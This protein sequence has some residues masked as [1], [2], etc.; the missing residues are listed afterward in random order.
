L[1][2]EEVVAVLSPAVGG[3]VRF[4]RQQ[5]REVDFLGADG[6]HFLTDDGFHLAEHPQSQRQPGVNAGSG[7][8]D[9]A[10]T[11]QQAVAGDVGVGRVFAQGAQEKGGK[12]KDHAGYP[13]LQPVAAFKL[14]Q[15][16][17]WEKKENNAP[18]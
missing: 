2:A 6:R 14:G 3:F 9:V 13:F 4:T 8:A 12:S 1:Q 17:S 11:H 16:S 18:L 5:G 15:Y 10:G 7:A